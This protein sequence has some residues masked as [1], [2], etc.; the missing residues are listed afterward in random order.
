MYAW[1]HSFFKGKTIYIFIYVNVLW[2]TP[3]LILVA[4]K[5]RVLAWRARN[6]RGGN[7]APFRGVDWLPLV[8][9]KKRSGFSLSFLKRYS[10]LGSSFSVLWWSRHARIGKAR[11]L[12]MGGFIILSS[13]MNHL[14]P[15]LF[16]IAVIKITIVVFRPQC[17]RSCRVKKKVFVLFFS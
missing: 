15:L 6:K 4:R 5:T 17:G 1:D 13:D 7:A 3:C 8:F 9:S 14:Y 11:V 2:Y 10:G 12:P 16:L